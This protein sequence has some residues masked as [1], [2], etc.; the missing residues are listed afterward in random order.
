MHAEPVGRQAEVGI[1]P[2]AHARGREE[3]VLQRQIGQPAAPGFAHGR[4]LD[5]PAGEAVD[6]LVG[7]HAR[8]QELEPVTSPQELFEPRTAE[9]HANRTHPEKEG[10][11]G[12]VCGAL[13]RRAGGAG[14]V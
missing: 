6:V 9:R 2:A 12:H 11:I 8:R 1:A 14:H 13:G 10:T 4:T 7:R 5:S 3:A